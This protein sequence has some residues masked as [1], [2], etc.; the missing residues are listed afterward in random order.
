MNKSKRKLLLHTCCAPC[1]APS[2]DKITLDEYEVV[3]FYCNSNI[4]PHKEYLKRLEHVRRLSKKM[5]IIIEEDVYNHDQWLS[6]IK[7][8]ENEPEKGKRCI[9]CFEFSLERTS[10]MADKLDIHAFATT[11]TLSPHKIS[12]IIFEIGSKYSKFIPYD[13]KKQGGFM[14]SIQ[15]CK[16]MDIYR[17]NY[18]GC[19][20]SLQK[21][22][23]K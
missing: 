11:L 18:C 3:L 14:K 21:Q 8:T 2:I 9:K 6:S 22:N 13:F 19:E 12:S 16:D 7:G 23:Q 5:D 10:L 15:L 4:Y 17:Q 20:F 1:A